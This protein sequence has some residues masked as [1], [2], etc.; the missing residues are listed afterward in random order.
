M[1]DLTPQP[2]PT[3][4]TGQVS[5]RRAA[6]GG[7]G[8][9]DEALH[10]LYGYLDGEL[11]EERRELIRAH[12]D[13]CGPCLEAFDFE[14]E[15]RDWSP[16]RCRSEAPESLRARV[17]DAHRATAKVARSTQ[18]PSTPTS[19]DVAAVWPGDH[20]RGSGCPMVLLGAVVW[21]YWIAPILV[22]ATVLALLGARGRLP[23]QGGHAQ[24]P[25]G[26][27]PAPGPLRRK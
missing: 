25:A 11:T 24:V 6:G 22:I 14:A 8:N 12:L 21:T 27:V 3:R 4:P 16:A 26:R 10:E 18:V 1:S 17:A 15:L 5:R 13:D 7:T 20:G 9:C 2:D 23:R 19:G